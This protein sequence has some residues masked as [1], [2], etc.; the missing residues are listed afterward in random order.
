MKITEAEVERVALLARLYL[1]DAEKKDYIEQLS[2]ILAYAA[3]L[4]ELDLSAV[5]PT[6]HAAPLFNVLRED[7]PGETM[8]RE[9]ILANAP[10]GEDGF[11]RVPRIV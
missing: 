10:D 5:E 3:R 8:R 1:T 11:F 2:G 4:Q 9:L 6:A 7:I